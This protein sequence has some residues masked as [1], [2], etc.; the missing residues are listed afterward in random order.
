MRCTSAPARYRRGTSLPSTKP[1]LT[2]PEVGFYNETFESNSSRARLAGQPLKFKGVF[3]G[4]KADGKA[5][6]DM[7]G[8][9]RNWNCTWLCEDCIWGF[10][11]HALRHASKLNPHTR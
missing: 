6:R 2:V 11:F 10:D 7:H 5:R 3:A 9:V 8:F 1:P 4:L